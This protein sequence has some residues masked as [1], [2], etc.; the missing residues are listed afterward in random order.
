M[1]RSAWSAGYGSLMAALDQVVD[2]LQQRGW[3]VPARQRV[4]ESGHGPNP[5]RLDLARGKARQ[6]LLAYAWR[7]TGEGKGRSG[8]NYRIQTTRTH[9][10]DLLVEAD[11]FTVGFGVDADRGVLAA[12]DGWTKRTTGSSSSVHIKRDLLDT[13]ATGGY[14]EQPPIWDGRAAAILGE[15][16]QL[17]AWIERQRAPR[18]AAVQALTVQVTGSTAEVTSDL[19]DG[20]PAAWLRVGDTFAIADRPGEHLVDDGLWRVTDVRVSSVQRATASGKSYPRNNV[21]ITG[22]RFGRVQDPAAVLAGL[23]R[24][25]PA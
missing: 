5:T 9:Q 14:A 18:Q 19:W 24:R 23:T 13:A 10:G 8:T 11:R 25:P 2:A 15:V 7:I 21:T 3:T 4:A 6:H 12:F 16:D 20:A 1:A 22:R 17:V